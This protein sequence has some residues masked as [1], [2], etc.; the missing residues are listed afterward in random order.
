MNK[1]IEEII[2]R[3]L[4]EISYTLV[5]DNCEEYDVSKLVLGDVDNLVEEIN[6]EVQKKVEEAKRELALE[7]KGLFIDEEFLFNKP[8][9]PPYG[10]TKED[11][12]ERGDMVATER[13]MLQL[14]GYLNKYISQTKG[15]EE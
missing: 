14:G 15:G 5:E 2:K 6:T 4:V 7:I 10:G 8:V 9:I 12:R 13:F 3:N 11:S 1:T